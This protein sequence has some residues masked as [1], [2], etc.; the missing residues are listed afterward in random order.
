MFSFG[1]VQPGDGAVRFLSLSNPN[2]GSSPL[3]FLLDEMTHVLKK[4]VAYA[5]GF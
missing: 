1:L 4:K 3:Y 2:T 5:V